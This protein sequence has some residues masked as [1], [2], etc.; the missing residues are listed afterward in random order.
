[1]APHTLTCHMLINWSHK[2]VEPLF[3][4]LLGT[5]SYRK[6]PILVKNYTILNVLDVSKSSVKKWLEKVTSE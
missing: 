1:M 4:R 3:P 2:T 6:L 5:I